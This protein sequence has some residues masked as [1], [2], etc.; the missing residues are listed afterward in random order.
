[1]K[2]AKGTSDLDATIRRLNAT[3]DTLNATVSSMTQTMEGLRALLAEARAKQEADAATIKA[4]SESVELLKGKLAERTA[5]A[6]DLEKA[7]RQLSA[8]VRNANKQ[9][10]SM[11]KDTTREDVPKEKPAPVKRREHSSRGIEVRVVDVYPQ[12][13]PGD[14]VEDTGLEDVCIRFVKVPGYIIKYEYH[15]H[16]QRVNGTLTRPEAPMAVAHNSQCDTSLAAYLIAQRCGFAMPVERVIKAINAMG[17]D[18]PKTDAFNI[19]EYSAAL[20]ENLGKALHQAILEDTYVGMDETYHRLTNCVK[21]NS[22]GKKTKKAYI[23]EIY[24]HMYRLVY[25]SFH[26][27][28]RS[29]EAGDKA[30]GDFSGIIQSDGYD[31]Y[32]R[33]DKKSGDITRIACVQHVKRV[34][35]DLG[36]KLPE[37]Q[38]MA[39]LYAEL[40]H[41]DHAHAVGEDGWTEAQH[42]RWRREY[43]PPI[44]DKIEQRCKTILKEG[45]PKTPLYKAAQYSINEMPAVRAIFDTAY[46]ELDN[47]VCERLNRDISLSRRNSL[48]FTSEGGAERTS[49]LYSL[50][51]SCKLHGINPEEYLKWAMD[52]MLEA[53]PLYKYERLR[54]LLPDMY[55]QTK[56]TWVSPEPRVRMVVRTGDQ[57]AK[58]TL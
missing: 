40:Y 6:A 52:R 41:N 16:K 38:A 56:L 57:T 12:T 13:D 29:D 4:L 21:P 14:E 18:L 46:C 28:S 26:H 22:D 36:K 30:L 49:M 50:V 53:P 45:V 42:L 19:I 54:P 44:L 34:W 1:M 55:Q 43:A 17:F 20:L 27:G 37:A 51:A 58:T 9:N 48:F 23:W 5:T 35:L 24:S 25:Y 7:N 11:S 8:I 10:E 32:R 31:F 47:N 33:L 39:E 2:K 3:I 15:L